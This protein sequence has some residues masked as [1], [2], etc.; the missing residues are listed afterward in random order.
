ML[1]DE[2]IK[3]KVKRNIQTRARMNKKGL[4]EVENLHM[5]LEIYTKSGR[6]RSDIKY[7][8]STS[9]K[10]SSRRAAPKSK[11]AEWL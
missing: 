11:K 2:N 4:E 3:G 9:T 6:T 1:L 10:I 8:R 7:G 5:P